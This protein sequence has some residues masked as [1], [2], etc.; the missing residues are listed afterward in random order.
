MANISLQGVKKSFKN[1][2]VIKGLDLVI[3]KGEF[4]TFVGPSG[5]GKSTLLN[6]IAGLED[7][8]DGNIY[9]DDILVNNLTPRER[10]VAMVFQS[11][12]LYPHMT[13]YE[14]IA[15]PLRMKKVGRQT[16]DSDVNRVAQLLGLA[17]LL[18]R[19]PKELSGGQRQRVALGRAIIRKPKVFLMD[20]PLSNLDARLRIDMR[21]ELKRLHQELRITTVYVTH[22]QEEAMSLSDRIAVIYQGEIQQCGSSYDIYTKPENTFVGGFIGIPPMNFMHGT[23]AGTNPFRMEVNGLILSPQVGR[24]PSRSRVIAGVR[25][26]DITVS[27]NKMEESLEVIVRIIEPAGSYNWVDVEWNTMRVK[28]KAS[29]IS[30]LSAGRKAFM[31]IPVGKMLIFD[32]D[33]GE[34]L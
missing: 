6:M 8:T 29:V 18:D 28:G 27:Y 2:V 25:P 23:V 14:N 21:T 34:R 32:A 15:F 26:E 33:S 11:Y 3:N 1:S 31:K 30:S 19:K 13:V 7:V 16:I 17:D 22:D 9:F 12:A 10:D 5:C 24:L 20:E 4:F